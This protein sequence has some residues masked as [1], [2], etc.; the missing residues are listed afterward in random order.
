MFDRHGLTD[1]DL[2]LFKDYVNTYA[3]DRDN[4]VYLHIPVEEYLR[5]WDT[6][7]AFLHKMFGDQLIIRE[8]VSYQASTDEIVHNMEKL[9]RR[10]DN[11]DFYTDITI[12]MRDMMCHVLTENSWV[13]SIGRFPEERGYIYSFLGVMNSP[14]DFAKNQF[15]EQIKYTGSCTN[16]KVP[17]IHAGEKIF[18]GINRIINTFE[19]FAVE[20]FEKYDESFF[21]T[22]R[23]YVEYYRLRHSQALNTTTLEGDLCLSIHPLDYITASDNNYGW[24]SCMTWTREDDPGEYR[25]GTVEMMN[26]PIV[27]VAYLE[28]DRPYYPINDGRTWSNKRWRE[29]FIVDRDIISSIRGYPYQSENLERLIVNKLAAMAEAAGYPTY[30]SLEEKMDPIVGGCPTYFET[31]NMYNDAQYYKQI[32][33]ASSDPTWKADEHTHNEYRSINYSGVAICPICG[34]EFN[35]NTDESEIL[36]CEDCE[37]VERCCDCGCRIPSDSAIHVDG[38]VYCDECVSTCEICDEVHPSYTMETI[39]A[40]VRYPHPIFNTSTD[41][42][43]ICMCERC[44]EKL[45]PFIDELKDT[46]RDPY[47]FEGTPYIKPNIPPPFRGEIIGAVLGSWRTEE[48]EVAEIVDPQLTDPLKKIS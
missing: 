4:D 32:Y 28:G 48:I 37:D 35:R 44:K 46:T 27:V 31:N 15:P 36:V 17:V 29:F 20:H 24:E 41:D 10:P 38:N 18:K 16:I 9:F 5:A 7:K 23:N 45:N 11:H 33:R 2:Q 13:D 25:L 12:P 6:D 30:L 8:H 47:L 40:R 14:D 22:L 39:Y 21:K 34:A 3:S 42:G 1:T 43:W 26:S 19:P